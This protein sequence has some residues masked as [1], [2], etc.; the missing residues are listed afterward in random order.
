MFLKV[1]ALPQSRRI[2]WAPC[3]V[4]NWGRDN[5]NHNPA[6]P[7]EQPA[8]PR[9]P[10]QESEDRFEFKKWQIF[11]SGRNGSESQIRLI[12]CPKWFRTMSSIGETF[13]NFDLSNSHEIWYNFST[14][15]HI[16]SRSS[17]SRQW[18]DFQYSLKETKLFRT[19][20]YSLKVS[21][22]CFNSSIFLLDFWGEV[23]KGGFHSRI[24]VAGCFER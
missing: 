23:I 3:T 17:I 21:L 8:G 2:S 20:S 24:P 19:K 10:G 6:G 18:I 16:F 7:R 11:S 4:Q 1:S 5:N 13:L 9:V 22:V 12:S 14:F 15:Q